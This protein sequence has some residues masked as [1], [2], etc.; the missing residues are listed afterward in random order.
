MKSFVIQPTV[1][2]R[3]EVALM[4]KFG[5]CCSPNLPAQTGETRDNILAMATEQIQPSPAI[6]AYF[7]LERYE[8]GFVWQPH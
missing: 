8:E 1:Y 2:D 5:L 6:L 7:D 3:S 4:V